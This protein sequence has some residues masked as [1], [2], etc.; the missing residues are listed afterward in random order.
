MRGSSNAMSPV[1]SPACPYCERDVAL[2]VPL[3]FGLAQCQNC[4]ERV[5]YLTVH[6]Q[7]SF[8]RY[9]AARFVAALF[10]G[11]REEQSLPDEWKLDALDLVELISSFEEALEEAS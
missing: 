7:R 4:G 1:G 9:E 2:P 3:P 10:H 6:S 8:F 5:W 11:L